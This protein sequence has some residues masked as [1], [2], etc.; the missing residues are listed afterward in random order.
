MEH[1][2]TLIRQYVR[3]MLGED[4]PLEFDVEIL[5]E[6]EF[7]S[8]VRAP[9]GPT[10]PVVSIT[11]DLVN[12]IFSCSSLAIMAISGTWS[13]EECR[14]KIIQLFAE[15]ERDGNVWIESV[16]S[17]TY[18]NAAE[19]LGYYSLE[20]LFLHE[21]CHSLNL[22]L[23]F[24]GKND[25]LRLYKGDN[26]FDYVI[27]PALGVGQEKS[28]DREAVDF[29]LAIARK[30]SSQFP[31]APAYTVYGIEVFLHCIWMIERRL[32]IISD[33]HPEAQK[34]ISSV[35]L[36]LQ[37]LHRVVDQGSLAQL[38]GVLEKLVTFASDR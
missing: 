31:A 27:V 10:R 4:W 3:Q 21:L 12:L 11:N 20:A 9:S 24:E 30:K 2:A 17:M 22:H 25:L 32:G 13:L 29:A 26:K 19:S 35:R 7:V 36:Q 6:R 15:W 1:D 33:S 28:A 18:R 34:R 14:E 16:G 37:V 5:R 8:K 38:Q 23:S